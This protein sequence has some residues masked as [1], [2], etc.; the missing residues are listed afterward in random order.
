MFPRYP[1]MESGDTSM[2]SAN[3]PTSVPNTASIPSGNGLNQDPDYLLF[4]K[5]KI[6]VIHKAT[7]QDLL[8]CKND[9][10]VWL[11][12]ERNELLRERVLLGAPEIEFSDI[13]FLKPPPPPLPYL[14][15]P[16]GYVLRCQV[17]RP[18]GAFYPKDRR[19]FDVSMQTNDTDAVLTDVN[20]NTLAN[21]SDAK[22]LKIGNK[23]RKID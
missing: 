2:P 1:L 17:S 21:N 16:N 14:V 11:L 7:L 6:A 4:F 12:S 10:I 15:W 20:L 5:A 9:A 22:A 23:K 13:D 3:G 8:C 18:R 19:L